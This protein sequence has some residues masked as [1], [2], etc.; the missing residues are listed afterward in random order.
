M[1]NIFQKVRLFTLGNIHSLLDAAIDLNSIAALKQHVRDLE[2]A[3]NNIADEAVRAKAD[4]SE[5]RRRRD[6][7]NKEINDDLAKID[8]LLSDSDTSNDQFAEKIAV[9]VTVAQGELPS[10]EEELATMEQ[11]VSAIEEA[12]TKV[13]AK[14][15][16]MS[17]KLTS[18]ERLERSAKAKDRA[19][20][21]LQSAGAS[22]GSAPSVDS[23]EVRMRKNAAVADDRFARSLGAISDDADDAANLS[24][25]RA[26]LEERLA[27]IRDAKKAA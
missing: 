26:L 9:R 22:L 8:Q 3:K 12:K 18:L 24:G 1:T 6:K 13:A 20:T 5:I 15:R 27:K 17:G 11:S 19:T 14:H 2:V 23:I 10:L 7:V 16:E 4:A 21:A 25:A